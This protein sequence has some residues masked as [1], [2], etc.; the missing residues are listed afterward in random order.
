[1]IRPT[2][3]CSSDIRH[4]NWRNIAFTLKTPGGI[5]TNNR[6]DR[7]R[8]PV[9]LQRALACVIMSAMSWFAAFGNAVICPLKER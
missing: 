1:M 4:I 6:T 5:T 3:A 7:H 2:G 9:R 8:R